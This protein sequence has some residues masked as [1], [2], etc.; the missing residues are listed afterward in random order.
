MELKIPVPELTKALQRVQGVVEKKTTMPI[1]ANVLLQ[2]TEDGKLS[3]SATNLEIGL[4]GAYDA[5]VTQP[6]S[7]TLAGKALFEIVR[8]LPEKTVTLKKSANNR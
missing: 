7:I 3:I 2:A 8:A 4:T 6:G 5:E 1:L